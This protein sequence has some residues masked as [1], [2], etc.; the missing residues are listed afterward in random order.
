MT[1]GGRSRTDRTPHR[2]I[3]RRLFVGRSTGATLPGRR[4]SRARRVV[5]SLVATALF[6]AGFIAT[7]AGV[8]FASQHANSVLVWIADTTQGWSLN[9]SDDG[10]PGAE[11]GYSFSY[12]DSVT[13]YA[14]STTSGTGDQEITIGNGNGTFSTYNA[15]IAGGGC[16]S[17]YSFTANNTQFGDDWVASSGGNSQIAPTSSS[18]TSIFTV[19][20]YSGPS[21]G[22][23]GST[24][25]FGQ[26]ASFCLP[27]SAGNVGGD[28]WS[29]SGAPP[30]MGYDG[31]NCYSG[32][33]SESGSWSGSISDTE[34]DGAGNG[35]ST[36]GYWTVTANQAPVFTSSPGATFTVGSYGAV[37]IS[38]SGYPGPSITESGALPPGLSFNGSALY[39]TPGAGG[40]G[41]WYP[42][43][44]AS[45][46]SGT[47]DQT[48][49]LTVNPEGTSIAVSAAAGTVDQTTSVSATVSPSPDGGTVAFSDTG[50]Y[51]RGCGAVPVSSGTASCNTAVLT[52]SGTDTVYAQ[53]EGD[54]SYATS[55]EGSTTFAISAASTSVTLA[56]SPSNPAVNT[57]STLTAT[58]S[59]RPDGG[60]VAFSDAKGYVSG[61]GAVALQSGLA[62]CV[63]GTI[64]SIATDAITAT[65]GGDANFKAS[66]G[67]LS[68]SPVPGTPSI[69]IASNP[70]AGTYGETASI[71]ATLTPAPGGGTVAFSDTKGYITGCGAVAVSGTTATCVT[72]T[73]AAAGS[74]AITATYSGDTNY[75]GIS[76]GFTLTIG[77]ASPLLVLSSSPAT[78]SVAGA[79]TI[80]ATV[81][82][83]PSGGTVAFSDSAGYITGCS[84]VAVS[85][86]TATCLTA[87]ITS[88]E[89]DQI[90]ATY[91]GD[92][93]FTTA[94][95]S[96]ELVPLPATTATLLSASPAIPDALGTTTITASVSPVPDGGTVAFT[97]AKG[98]ITGCSSVTVDTTSGSASCTTQKLTSVGL[99]E[100][101]ATFSGNADYSSSNGTLAL[102]VAQIPTTTTVTASPSPVQVTSPT[103][104][105]ATISPIPD[106]GTVAFSDTE[107]AITTLDGCGAV[108]VNL[109]TG[110][111]SCETSSLPTVGTDDVTAVFS[112]DVTYAPSNDIASVTVGQVVESLAVTTS[113]SVAVTGA[114]TTVE[115]RLSHPRQVVGPSPLATAGATS[116]AAGRSRSSTVRRRAR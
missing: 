86:T 9:S 3:V 94:N 45:S 62:T 37:G 42:T 43:F 109:S 40:G 72:G 67:N 7:T 28:N 108:P 35:F 74:D 1:Y 6:A 75:N 65:Y 50:G 70:G 85:S 89:P 64:T 26:D 21:L 11:S 2:R 5:T 81:A 25:T 112:G 23:G 100:V 54:A 12:G 92:A 29:G 87:T 80:T 115:A 101:A 20:G 51:I 113:P 30:G 93:N 82:P 49:S 107:G 18:W 19:S 27:F 69:A 17:G 76:G 83:A 36:T 32:T 71:T 104:L 4:R 46:S 90:A 8:A 38:A 56:A 16:V 114:A 66:T 33:P 10:T 106:G 105:T 79:A 41:T 63:T 61:C 34:Y 84:T 97:D 96:L 78:P 103:I 13:I 68:L 58:L 44:I 57:D 14:C 31:N 39:G 22:N 73:L 98:F 47:T 52:A 48:F 55:P 116:R 110:R 111:A 91:S 24:V 53:Y 59:P 15:V 88:V 60:T 95:A 99:D 77:K 102:S